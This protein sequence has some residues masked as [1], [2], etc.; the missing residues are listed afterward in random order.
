MSK[1]STSLHGKS[2]LAAV[3]GLG[4]GLEPAP[5]QFEFHD[6]GDDLVRTLAELTKDVQRFDSM[7]RNQRHLLQHHGADP[8][9]FDDRL[10]HR[11]SRRISTEVAEIM[12]RAHAALEELRRLSHIGELVSL[13]ALE[14]Q[15]GGG[16]AQDRPTG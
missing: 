10:I 11:Q 6:A 9:A 3:S 8:E 4:R 1:W 5:T 14:R 7:I 15:Y 16:R 13:E 12:T 2:A